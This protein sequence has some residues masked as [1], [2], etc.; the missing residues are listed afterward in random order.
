[1]RV[2]LDREE[3]REMLLT[4]IAA[5]NFNGRSVE[6]VYELKKSIEAATG[7]SEAD[8]AQMLTPGRQYP[9]K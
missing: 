5:S 2:I 9:P 4:L 1:V 6:Q 8:L 3:H 7:P